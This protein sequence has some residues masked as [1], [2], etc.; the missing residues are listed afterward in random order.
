MKADILKKKYFWL[1]LVIAIY[2]GCMA[3]FN[4]E[5]VTVHHR[6]SEFYITLGV[7]LLVIILLVI[8]LKK[9]D[10]LRNRG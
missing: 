7:E 5:T 1:P 8:F 2:A 3:W 4:R 6:Y 10:D 9:R